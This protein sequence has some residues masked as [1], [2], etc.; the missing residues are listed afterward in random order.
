[1]RGR[2]VNVNAVAPGPTATEL[3]FD[4]K[5]DEVIAG[6]AQA[7]PFER[8]G[9]PHEI[10]EVAAFLASQQGHW[11]NGQVVRANGGMV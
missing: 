11:I 2:D 3:F 7:N 8:L 4:G 6:L 1:M 9:E 10:A 5:S